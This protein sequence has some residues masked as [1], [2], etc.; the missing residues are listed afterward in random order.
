MFNNVKAKKRLTQFI[1]AFVVICIT[2]TG[3]F[4]LLEDAIDSASAGTSNADVA[5]A[6]NWTAALNG[7]GSGDVVNMTV[8]ADFAVGATL[9]EIPSGVTVNLNMN[10]KTIYRDFEGEGD[11]YMNYAYPAKSDYFGII[12]NSGTLNITGTGTIRMKQLGSFTQGSQRGEAIGRMCS[13]VNNES[14]ILNISNGINI[15]TY[16]A[17]ITPKSSSAT[18]RFADVFLYSIGVYN[19]GTVNC[20]GKIHTGTF[21]GG[22]ANQGTSSYHY[23]FAYGIYGAS[24][25]VNI[26]GGSITAEAL[27]GA[28]ESTA[29]CAERNQVCNFAVGVYSNNAIIKG[30]TSITTATSSWMSQNSYD[31]WSSGYNMSWSVGVM[32]STTNYPVIGASVDITSSFK[33]VNGEQVKVPGSANNWAYTVNTSD[34]PGNYGRRAYPVAGIVAN[35]NAAMSGGQKTE[36]TCDTGFFG[37]QTTDSYGTTYSNAETYLNAQSNYYIAEGV[38]YDIG[39]TSN[40]TYLTDARSQIQKQSGASSVEQKFGYLKNGTP[41]TV[42]TQYIILYRFYEGSFAAA[43][44]KEVTANSRSITPSSGSGKII[45]K[46]TVNIGGTHDQNFTMDDGSAS[47]TFRSGGVSRNSRY[48]EQTDTTFEKV[49]QGTF[50]TKTISDTNGSTETKHWTSNGTPLTASGVSA[51]SEQ[52]IVVYMNYIL[53]APTAVRIVASNSAIDQYTETKSFTASYTGKALVPGTDFNLGIIDMGINISEDTNDTSDDTVVTNVYNISGTGSGSGNN[54]TAVTYRY[55]T[56]Q[57]NWTNGLPKDVGTYTIEVNVNADT[58]FASTGT[59][60]RQA[61]TTIITGTIT[62]VNVTIGGANSKTGT[63]GST[64]GE[65]IPFSEYTVTGLG[66]DALEGSWSYAGVDAGAYPNAGQATIYLA[67][68]PTAGTMTANNYNATTFGVALNVNKRPV[69]VNA[70]AS[71]VTY[72]DSKPTYALAYENLADCDED[73]KA[74][75][76]NTS[77]F[78]V[79]YNG[80]WV[81]YSAGIP[82]GNYTVKINEFGG[83]ADEN[84]T[85]S[86][87]VAEGAFTV[88][89][90]SIVYSATAIDR[91]YNGS[92]EVDVK[93]NYVSGNFTSDIYDTTINTTGNMVAG[94]NAGNDK[95]VNVDTSSIII[96]NSN[97]YKLVIN[98][99][100]AITVNISKADPTGVA[101]VA[102]PANIVY[103]SAKSLATATTLHVTASNIP[104]NWNWKDSSIVPTVDVPTYT[105]IFT[106]TDTVNYNEIE[107]AVSLT[108]EQKEVVVTVKEFAISYGDAVPAISGSVT[109]TG[110][111]GSDSVATIGASGGVETTTTYTRGAGIG[112]YPVI[113][114]STL[115]STNYYFTAVNNKIVVSPRTLT[116]T[117]ADQTVTYGAAVPELDAADLKF[118]GFYGTDNYTVLGGTASVTTTYVP[119]ADVGTYPVIAS[120]YT[121]T[122]YAINYVN[123][124]LTVNKAV[125]TVKP[126]DVKGVTYGADAPAYA[127][128]GLYSFSG[129]VAGDTVE[130]VAITGTPAFT[131]GYQSGKDAGSYPVTVSV[132]TLESQNYTFV[133]SEGTLTVG[134]AT[135]VV[136]EVPGATVVNSHTFAEATF[137]GTEIV[138]NPNKANIEVEGTFAFRDATTVATWGTDGMYVAVYTPADTHNYNT[139]TVEV[140]LEILEKTISGK[141]VIQGSAMSG[142]TLTVNLA[143][144]DPTQALNYTFQWYADDAQIAGATGTTY[145]LSDSDIGKQFHVVLVANESLGFKGTASSDKTSKVIQALLETTA[146]Q[147]KAVFADV[148]YD[149]MSHGATVTVADG[150]NAQYFGDITV[151]YNGLTKAPTN[152]GTYIVTVDVGTPEEPA[153]G[154]PADTY[155]GPA[156]GIEVGTFKITPAPFTV[157]VLAN[158]KVYD[159]TVAATATV[160]GSG[161]KDEM[162]DVRIA[163]GSKF[164]FSDA[165]VGTD[166]EVKV[167]SMQLIGAQAFN[168]EIKVEPVLADI[169]PRTLTARATGVTK[170]Y[171]GSALVTVTF[172]NIEGYAPVDSA[173]TVYLTN[174]QATATSADA[175]TQTLADITCT[176]A[177]SSAAN[178]VVAYSNA[179]TA[180][181]VITPATPNVEAPVISGVEYDAAKT[182]QTIDLAPYTTSGGFW[183]FNDLTIVPTVSQ[184]TYAATFKST[185]KNY[186]DLVTVITVN[187]DPRAVVL[188]ADD[189]TIT[190]GSKSPVF[191]ITATGLTGE[192]TLADIGGSC[193][194]VCTYAPGSAIGSYTINLNNAL[195]DD[196]Y[197]FSTVPGTLTVAPGRINVTAAATDKVYDGTADITVSFAIV[198]G[199]YGNDDVSLNVTSTIGQ[200]A[201]ANAGKTTVTYTAPILVGSKAENYELY[202]T[203]ASGTLAAEITKADVSG[204]TFPVDGVVE[205]GYDLRYATF[206]IDGTGDGSFAFENAKDIVPPELGYYEYKVIFTPTDARNYNTQEAIISLEVVKCQLNYVVGVA[207]TAQVGETLAVVTTGLPAMAENY[208]QYQWFRSDGSKL[209]AINGANSARYVATE[210]DVGYTLV[211][212]TFFNDADPYVFHEDANVE[213]IDNG[214]TY[215]I[216]G[217]SKDAIK[218]IAL[219]F[220]QRLINW[221]YRI[222]A[223]IT[224]VKL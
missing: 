15:N 161:L 97:N 177:G 172:S 221:I 74:E 166:K 159:G 164:A 11:A 2:L 103:D 47:L 206:K 107:Q 151:K 61:A 17:F 185:N 51:T 112:E 155:Y 83:I 59:Y 16:S 130:T 41:G 21:V 36:E 54:A 98:N 222:I 105:A 66:S 174:G 204:I 162:D 7:K 3:S 223:A 115:T 202:V 14:G 201:T 71:F 87:N 67:W 24:G 167:T 132:N 42:G 146:A 12:E 207:G 141:P 64:Y 218:E 93:L 156:T 102:D 69:N 111:T 50:A 121:S 217:Q 154:Y 75:W 208:I 108:V 214:V 134:K 191:T 124:A 110:F 34:D 120:G 128:N 199:K 27:S 169:T 135:P 86:V 91:A 140:Y 171:D 48:Y 99:I 104:G 89:P 63:Y 163:E 116:I 40:T 1:V 46:A 79:Y 131:T 62:K 23:A 68:T 138:V 168:Y 18:E 56:D 70:G 183:Q 22:V 82:A 122:N 125:L 139:T 113:V 4:L 119:G 200:A 215:G 35:N 137:D 133:G 100:D 160:T 173:S 37:Q 145:K 72:G 44:L 176:L 65:L 90:R 179:A 55:T 196:N 33:L 190:Y 20:A 5:S 31:I 53:R 142:S 28:L 188:T 158:D 117:A 29:S 78:L 26:T 84:N 198:S 57:A 88:Q 220:W 209:V 189:K 32:Y 182:L 73:M 77:S 95:Q 45:S 6:A 192:D 153:G 49:P 213:T 181:V 109:Y 13:I 144:M 38:F 180:S 126:N 152:A 224:G 187:V 149:A 58:T 219:S 184:K 85:F 123:G 193:T 197:I 143:S 205:F 60:N 81:E 80:E 8:T 114:V 76:F 216:I 136:N 101:V 9:T 194:P 94:A 10:G 175:G 52:V 157:T 25:T 30:D 210:D 211:V 165:K 195:S 43:N 92:A 127:A 129:F 19:S 170:V 148:E 150:Y 39:R 212:Y 203:P 186:T 118:E 106:P 96:K 147:L 178:Y